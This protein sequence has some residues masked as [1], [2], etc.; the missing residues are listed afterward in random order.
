MG[1]KNFLCNEER[2]EL[3]AQH[4]K[5]RDKKIC[6]RIKA[7]LLSDKGWTLMQIAEAL[8]L[9]DDA[10]RRHIKEYQQ[11]RKLKP[12]SG[13]SVEKLSIE[14]SDLLIRHL[15]QYIYLYVKDIVEYV[16]IEFNVEYTIHGLRNWL[17]RHGFTY[18]KPAVVPGKADRAAQEKWL[19]EYDELKKNLPEDETIC[20]TDGVHPTHNVQPAYG[21]IKKG[22]RKEVP[23]NSGRARLNLSGIIDIASYKVIVT[24]DKTLNADAMITFFSGV[25]NAYP[26]KKKIHVFCDN[27]RYYRNKALNA[28][29]KKSKIELHFLPPYSPNLNPIERLWKWMKERV[30]YNAYY[31]K[32]EDFRAA[33]FGFFHALKVASSTSELGTSLRSRIGDR[34]SPVGAPNSAF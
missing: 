27:A 13:G 20:F 17:K 15:E 16:R 18:K 34:F 26:E 9:S 33:V 2:E 3:I 25:E 30:I 8:L 29:L 21:W 11:S 7:V 4:K 1:M 32:F 28:Y 14:Q 6:D 24:E 19:L 12:V 10:V 22:E 5:E 31:E 23:A